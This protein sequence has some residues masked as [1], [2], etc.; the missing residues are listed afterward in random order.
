MATAYLC[1]GFLKIACLCLR[2]NRGFHACGLDANCKVVPFDLANCFGQIYSVGRTVLTLLVM[3]T[4]RRYH[5][6]QYTSSGGG[7]HG[8]V[9][10]PTQDAELRH[11][12]RRLSHHPS[13]VHAIFWFLCPLLFWC[14][15][16]IVAG[17]HHSLELLRTMKVCTRAVQWQ[18]HATPLLQ[19]GI[20]TLRWTS[21]PI[22]ASRLVT[23]QDLGWE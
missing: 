16:E 8:P 18:F 1:A 20:A 19:R 2:G 7:T 3:P 15:F 5:D 14:E 23:S 12:I 22:V 9:V 10:T 13:I 11:Q 6:M 21:L 4:H 17:L